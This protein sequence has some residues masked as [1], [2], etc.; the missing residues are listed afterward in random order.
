M[1]NP[2]NLFGLFLLSVLLFSTSCTSPQDLLERGDYDRA[3]DLALRKMAGKKK[4]KAKH[5]IALESAFDKANQRDLY[6]AERLKKEGREENWEE[7][8]DIYAKIR[9]RQESIRPLLPL[10]DDDGVQA[11]FKFVKIDDLELE[12]KE[13]AAEFHYQEAQRLL[14]Q[15]QRGD[16]LAAREAYT[17]LETINRFYRSYKDV[18][19]LENMALALGNTL[20]YLKMENSAPVVLSRDFERELLS[21]PLRN[22]NSRW[23]TFITQKDA[24]RPHHYEVV[25]R[26]TNIDVSPEQVRE[27]EYEEYK[28]IEEGF[29]YVLD[30][31]GNV[32]KD[33]LGNDVTVPAKVR[34]RAQVLETLQQKSANVSGVLE[35][36]DMA[37][38]TLVERQ[39]ISVNT[40]F[41]NYASTFRGDRRALS[42]ET[43]QRIGNEPRPFPPDELM[44]IQAAEE[45]KPIVRN[46]LERNRKM[47]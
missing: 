47:I 46:L 27:R 1:K 7:I 19:Q 28:E 24:E 30:E 13:N 39:P 18:R 36:I 34:V 41:E 42:P 17:S 2:T 45:L 14:Q 16:R 37:G 26:L 22:L 23:K 4:K 11:K 29:E 25:I 43:K 21:F 15:A 12:A 20:V 44:L 35:I 40:H 32:L 33:S 38:G 10:I 31:K 5:V 3:I 8:H 6:W 9:R